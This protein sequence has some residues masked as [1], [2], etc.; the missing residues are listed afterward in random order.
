M[1][2]I[3]L[4][5]SAVA[6]PTVLPALAHRQVSEAARILQ[7]AIAGAR[8]AAI[9]DN[10]PSGIRLLPD[11]VLNGLDPT[12][13]VLSRY[14]PLA[15]NRIIPIEAAPDYTS[16][17]AEII[18]P[19]TT[20][21]TSTA[22]LTYPVGGGT[23]IYPIGVPAGPATPASPA[24]VLMVAEVVYSSSG[25]LNPQ[26]NW[27]WNMRVG[28]KIQL[29]NAGPWYTIIGP[30]LV[31]PMNPNYQGQNPELFVNVGLPGA[32]SPLNLNGS[33]PNPEFLFLVNGQDD[34]LNGWVDE[35]WDGVDN[36]NNVT[37][38]EYNPTNLTNNEW[39]EIETW[40]GSSALAS[41]QGTAL[42]Y[43]IQRRPVPTINAREI[44]FPSDVVIDGSSWGLSTERTRVPTAA[45]NQYSGIIELVI[46]PDGSVLPTTVYSSPSSVGLAGSFYHF[47]LAER[48]DVYAPPPPTTTGTTTT[49]QTLM[50]SM[51]VTGNYPFY[52]PMPLS[53]DMTGTNPYDLLV[54][55]NPSLPVL[56]GERRIVTLFSKSGQ[57]TTNENPI[58]N[59]NSTDWPYIQAQQGISGGQQ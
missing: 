1:I 57:V 47:W 31:A 39:V 42:T 37:A 22:A 54:S 17:F 46:N 27:F 55:Q 41:N 58:F 33:S 20:L 56:K 34:N 29:N 48:G 36:N 26:T 6:L 12:T 23:N 45:F 14:Q 35:G 51:G 52:L 38:D 30:L 28:D 50:A 8:D 25:T 15:Y 44:S 7:G 10:A 11:P 40:L 2:T 32:T 59:V 4:I 21:F 24:Q 13:G 43:T 18:I 3:I 49:P 19:S 5:V 53:S 9:R 16:G